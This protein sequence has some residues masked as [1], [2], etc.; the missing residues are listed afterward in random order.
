M[1]QKFTKKLLTWLY[2]RQVDRA[3]QN[4]RRLGVDDRFVRRSAEAVVKKQLSI[5]TP[6]KE[7][8]RG[9]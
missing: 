6:K 9:Y 2:E 4:L 3:E 7:E 8:P 5:R 1:I